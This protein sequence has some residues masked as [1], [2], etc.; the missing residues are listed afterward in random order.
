[1]ANQENL[2][3]RHEFQYAIRYKDRDRIPPFVVRQT[4]FILGLFYNGAVSG[5]GIGRKYLQDYTLS[6]LDSSE[7]GVDRVSFGGNGTNFEGIDLEDREAADYANVIFAHMP[8]LVKSPWMPM[9]FS[10]RGMLRPPENRREFLGR[11]REL[12]IGLAQIVSGN[13]EP[14]AILEAHP[15][16]LLTFGFFKV[17]AELPIKV[18]ESEIKP[19]VM[20]RARFNGLLDGIGI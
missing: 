13:M 11:V 10:R 15:Y 1:M 16:L 9:G 14:G 5:D 6:F 3:R 7:T 4:S 17:G 12:R 2:G 20:S 8:D 19:E 18:P